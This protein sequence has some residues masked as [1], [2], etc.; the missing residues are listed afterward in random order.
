[1]CQLKNDCDA[2]I[3]HGECT[4]VLTRECSH[5][6][7]SH[8]CTRIHKDHDFAGAESP[9]NAGELV[10]GSAV[11]QLKHEWQAYNAKPA[12]SFRSR[13]SSSWQYG[14]SFSNRARLQNLQQAK[15]HMYG[16]RG[17]RELAHAAELNRY[18]EIVHKPAKCLHLPH[19]KVRHGSGDS[20]YDRHVF[21]R[22]QTFQVAQIPPE[23]RMLIEEGTRCVCAVVW[24]AQRDAAPE[25]SLQQG[26]LLVAC[27]TTEQ[28]HGRP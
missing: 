10:S 3:T 6:S 27:T 9:R 26:V 12:A 1:M 13:S 7:R 18:K 21:P 14:P 22:K 19:A 11:A 2:R 25:S 5:I 23:A 4:R 16:E 24:R 20:G 28:M 17:R 15:I 8:R